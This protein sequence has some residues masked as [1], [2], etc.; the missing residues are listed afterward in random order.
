LI[1]FQVNFD[2]HV[3]LENPDGKAPDASEKEA[4]V[5]VNLEYEWASQDD[6][7]EVRECFIIM[8]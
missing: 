8:S 6:S 2:I 7:R 4:V 5:E 1:I 3:C